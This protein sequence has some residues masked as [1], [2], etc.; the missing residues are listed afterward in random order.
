L[1]ISCGAAYSIIHKDP[2]YHKICARWEQRQLTDK[3]KQ[4]YVEICKEYCEGE[5]FLQWMVT[6]DETWVHHYEPLSK[7]Q[8]ME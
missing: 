6:G 3:H 8:S 5:A 1:D 4:A 2:R 7:Y